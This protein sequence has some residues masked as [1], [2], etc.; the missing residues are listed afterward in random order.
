M[1]MQKLRMP[2][3]SPQLSSQLLSR[4]HESRH[5]TGLGTNARKFLG[6]EVKPVEQNVGVTYATHVAKV[7]N[8]SQSTFAELISQVASFFA[9]IMTMADAEKFL[10]T[11]FFS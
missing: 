4:K 10:T 6:T 7:W 9:H 8:S 5:G 11:M 3:W 1:H 2:N